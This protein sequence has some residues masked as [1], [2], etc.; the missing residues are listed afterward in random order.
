MPKMKAIVREVYGSPDVVH[1]REIDI[2]TPDDDSVLIRIQA[3]S[4]NPYDLHAMTGTP[5]I[6]RPQMGFRRPKD[7]V[8]GVDVAGI[9]ESVGAGVTTLKAG[10]EV[11]GGAKGSFAEYGCA[12]ASSVVIKP[13]ELSF[14]EAAAMSMAGLTALQGLRDKGKVTAG[15]RVLVNG[16][17]G[18]VGTMA[19][20]IAKALG[21][22]VTGVCSTGN[23]DMVRSIGADHVIDYTKG[24]F[25][26]GGQ[27]F[28]VMIDNV[29]N[30]SLRD[31]VRALQ[32]KGVYVVVGAPDN[33]VVLGPAAGIFGALARSPFVSQKVAIFIAKHERQDLLVLADLVRS[34]NL[35]PVID[36]TYPLAEGADALRHVGRGHARG[37]TVIAM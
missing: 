34:G 26:E 17:G 29:G 9:V 1:L 15:Q 4:V 24:D 35:A 6:A 8:L 30:R 3:A 31:C 25:V 22:E 13:T 11:F 37:K 16:A 18:G 33:G 19:V 7:P 12:R 14:P 28:D 20:Q 23:V 32:P 5:Y 27:R 36:R 2:P 21:A 10:D